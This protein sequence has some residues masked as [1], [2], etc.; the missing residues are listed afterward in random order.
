MRRLDLFQWTVSETGAKTAHDC[1]RTM[2]GTT[3]GVRLRLE[4]KRDRQRFGAQVPERT[5]DGKARD[6]RLGGVQKRDTG[7]ESK[8][9]RHEQKMEKERGVMLFCFCT[10]FIIYRRAANRFFSEY[11]TPNDPVFSGG[12]AILEHL[13]P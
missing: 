12:R 6:V 10:L 9:N 3:C 5:K 4:H 8:Y 2:E 13:K 11:G 7:A 1:P